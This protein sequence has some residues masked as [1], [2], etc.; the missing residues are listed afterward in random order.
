MMKKTQFVALASIGLALLVI[1]FISLFGGAAIVRYLANVDTKHLAYEWVQSLGDEFDLPGDPVGEH[2]NPLDYGVDQLLQSMGHQDGVVSVANP[3]LFEPEQHFG[4]ITGYAIYNRFRMRFVAGGK[5][6]LGDLEAADIRASTQDVMEARHAHI[7]EIDTT[8]TKGNAVSVVLI[9]LVRDG[10][11]RGV[12]QIEVVGFGNDLFLQRGVQI[13]SSV[14]ALAVAAIGLL[15]ILLIYNWGRMAS[16]ATQK[17]DFLA[18]TDPV[19]LLPNRRKFEEALPEQ[20]ERALKNRSEIVV[21]FCDVDNFKIIN[22]IY[23]HSSGDRLLVEIGERLSQLVPNAGELFRI[24][25]D[26]FAI[27]LETPGGTP[28]IKQI[29]EK[30]QNVMRPVLLPDELGVK[31]SL[32]CGVARFPQDGRDKEQLMKAA[33]LALYSA[34]SAGRSTYRLFTKRM[35]SDSVDAVRLQ[36]ALEVAISRDEL[37]LVYQPQVKA[38]SGRLVG[39]EAL[40][41]WTHLVEGPISPVRFV[42]VAEKSG[43]IGQLGEW[44]LRTACEEAKH[45]PDHMSIAVNLSPMQLHDPR[46]IKTIDDILKATSVAPDR[47]EIEVTESVMMHDT[48]LSQ[49]A[50]EAI[51]E[52]GVGLALDDFG[53]GFSSLSYLTRI[54]L[55]K[56]KIDKSFV[57][58]FGNSDRDDAIVTGLVQLSRSLGLKITAEG[59]ETSAQAVGL[60]NAGC[61]SLQGFYFGRPTKDP[62][63]VIEKASESEPMSMLKIA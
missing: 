55:T 36:H 19:T 56:I 61:T 10:E 63:A 54:P 2:R 45:W 25:G 52:L 22:D 34:K 23:G 37:H 24:S 17:A 9:P 57:D 40:A 20:I 12:A 15:A 11:I 16:R 4:Q 35:N 5:R 42:P 7:L 31:A 44:A 32:S 14:T 27:I 18:S 29:C 60:S 6:V 47:L 59:I 48:E 3:S 21:I 33:D 62:N 38:G 51:R 13:V 58:R 39:F 43:L 49:R 26:H 28:Q 1:V 30:I 46:L 50:F 53:T 8:G 41:R